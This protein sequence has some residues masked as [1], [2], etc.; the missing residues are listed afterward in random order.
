MQMSTHKL[1]AGYGKLAVLHGIDFHVETGEFVAI[2]GA[3]GAGKTTLMKTLA[4]ALPVIGGDIRLGRDSITK[5]RA[6]NAAA[7]GIAYVPQEQNVFVDLSVAENLS[8]SARKGGGS[9]PLEMVY[10]RFGFLA[11]RADQLAGSLSG[12]ERQTLAVSMAFVA[13]PSLLLLDEPTTG[14]SPI[15]CQTLTDWIVEIAAAGVTVVWIVEQNP[16]PVLAAASRAYL[17]DG[18]QIKF[19]GPA[20]EISGDQ[21]V[22]MALQRH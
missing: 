12:G 4:R 3:N 17:I 20:S 8:L 11:E 13:E 1:I 2:L 22:E 18:G 15:V 9:S 16:E 7:A 21:T 14:L 19:E 10:D 5:W 6:H